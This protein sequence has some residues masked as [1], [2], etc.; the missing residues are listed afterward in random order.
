MKGMITE[1]QRFSLNDG[2]GIRTTVFFKGCNMKC[3]WCHNPETLHFGQELLFYPTKCI[4]CGHCFTECPVGAHYLSEAGEHCIDRQSCINCGKCAEICYADAVVMCGKEMSVEDVMFH[5]TQ[6]K[7]YY[8]N[9]GGGVTLSGGEVFMQKDFA[10]SLV[11]Y[12]K[13]EGIHTAIESNMNFPVDMALDLCSKVDLIMCDIKIFD[14]KSH[15]AHTGVSNSK[16]LNN[17]K[18]IDNLG[19]PTIVRT[20]LIPGIT[21]TVD[22]ISS[23]SK[24]I[25]DMKNLVRYEMLNFNPLGASKYEGLNIKNPCKDA[26]PL[27]KERLDELEKIATVNVAKVKVI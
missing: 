19:I 1:I 9:S 13:K 7:A 18:L 6:D 8:E 15:I 12:C 5:I 11:E 23:I 17:I 16:I 25:S 27:K 21:D 4:G 20:P 26:E 10:V 22:N 24:Y 3:E 14:E 2:P